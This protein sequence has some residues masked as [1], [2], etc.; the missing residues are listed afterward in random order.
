MPKVKLTSAEWDWILILLQDN[1]GYISD[2]LFR[3]IDK[4]LSKQEH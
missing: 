2:P 1:P 4:Q 3:E